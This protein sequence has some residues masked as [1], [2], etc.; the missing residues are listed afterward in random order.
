LAQKPRIHSGLLATLGMKPYYSP[1]MDLLVADVESSLARRIG[2]APQLFAPNEAD[3]RV[4]SWLADIAGDPAGR[5]L[6]RLVG[7]HPML[8]SLLAGIAEGSPFLWELARADPVRLAVLLTSDPDRRF[9]AI[10]ADAACSIAAADDD[11]TVMRLLRRMKSEA[12]LLIALADIGGVWP[13]MR[14]TA[15]LTELAD[16]AVGAAVRHLLDGA[17]RQGRLVPRDRDRPEHGSG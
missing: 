7:D 1:G 16:A 3:A 13:V 2:A 8:A 17:A 14:V 15:A 10:L 12:A 9:N 6:K 11:A 5:T 4:A